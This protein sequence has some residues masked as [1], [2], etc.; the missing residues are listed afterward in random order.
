MTALLLPDPRRLDAAPP[1]QSDHAERPLL[2]LAAGV[3]CLLHVAFFFVPLPSR[4]LPPPAPAVASAPVIWRTELVPPPLP[5]APRP[6]E[7]RAR[8]LAVPFDLPPDDDPVEEPDLPIV[9]PSEIEVELPWPSQIDAPPA[10]VGILDESTEGL[11]PPVARPGHDP[12]EYPRTSVSVRQEGRV[13]LRAVIT[14][15]G[16]VESIEVV[17]APRPELGLS[18]AAIE[19]VRRWEYAPGTLHGRPVSVRLTVVV[20]FELD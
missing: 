5:P 11:I 19:A 6:F 15:R 13:I 4:R 12:P 8:L 3:A 1:T 10:Q 16:R 17:R 20:D 2:F 7:S 14:A 9:D 18:R